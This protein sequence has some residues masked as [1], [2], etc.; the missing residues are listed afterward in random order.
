MLKGGTTMLE[1]QTHVWGAG[2]V[3][4]RLAPSVR[5]ALDRRC[6]GACEGC[7]LDWR[8][9]LYVFKVDKAAPGAAAN[10]IVLCGACSSERSGDFA[11]FVGIPS[12]RDRI[13]YA[14]NRRGGTTP[15]TESRRRALIA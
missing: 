10:L 2:T 8:W 1:G 15:M 14:N 9:A 4:L 7:G 13:L 12:T 5:V 3:G 11:L 6:A